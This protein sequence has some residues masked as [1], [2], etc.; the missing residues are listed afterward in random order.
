MRSNFNIF[1][2]DWEFLGTL[3]K[4]A[5]Q[6][7]YRD[8]NAAI[9]KTRAFAE[10]L[11]DV[12]FELESI[13]PLNIDSQVNKLRVLYSEDVLSEEIVEIFHN[14]RKTGN[15]ASH[16]GS[17][18]TTTEAIEIIRLAFYISCWFME[19]YVSYS[20][21]A[22]TFIQPPDKD[23]EKDSRIQ[24]L[25]KKLLLQEE[26]REQQAEKIQYYAKQLQNSKGKDE[27]KQ[28]G[29]YKHILLMKSKLDV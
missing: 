21:E 25:E 20:F 10:K 1:V 26:Q 22:P 28:R 18:G 12:V 7:V 17:Y 13:S 4:S 15:K 16:D 6:H 5:E 19:V 9:A 14:I 23:K 2:D 8:P 29:T 11:T 3:G 27:R 24:E